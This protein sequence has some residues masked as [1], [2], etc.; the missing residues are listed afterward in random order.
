M[1]I[2]PVKDKLDIIVLAGQ[3]N[4]E[5]YG[6]GDCTEPYEPTVKIL[7]MWDTDN[8]GFTVNERPS[9]IFNIVLPRKYVIGLSEERRSTSG[10]IGC[11]A[12]YFARKYAEERLDS[13]RRVL[14]IN[15]AVGATGFAKGHWKEDGVLRQRA[16]RM[17][18]L[19]LSMN[20]ENRIVAF[21]WHQGEHDAYFPANILPDERY[22]KTL[23]NLG[24]LISDF[25]GRYGKIPFITGGFTPVWVKESEHNVAVEN[26][27][28][29]LA[30]EKELIAFTK[31]DGLEVNDDAVGN[32]DK[33]HFC[34]NSLRLLGER[35][36][37]NYRKMI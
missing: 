15:A 13:D 16:I 12:P 17:C 21:L 25:R 6:L 29:D 34:R 26:A 37:E 7:G 19:A 9:P 32:G 33:I 8:Q 3:S 10:K 14:I 28:R 23:A 5:G 31:T 24:G 2:N 11:L 1:I 35:Y 18:D 27:M 20:P 22:R 4:G 36:Y 30:D